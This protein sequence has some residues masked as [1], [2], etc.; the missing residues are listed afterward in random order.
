MTNI[1]PSC[2]NSVLK[3][4]SDIIYELS[5][6]VCNDNSKYT[7][8]KQVMEFKIKAYSELKKRLEELQ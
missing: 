5:C 6:N 2:K 1:C 8:A 3:L 4:L 7:N